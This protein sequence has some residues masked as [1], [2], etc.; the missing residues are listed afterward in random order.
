MYEPFVVTTTQL[1][2][3]TVIAI[4]GEL[5][6]ATCEE[7][8]AALDDA[9]RDESGAGIGVDLR[10]LSFC[11]SSGLKVLLLAMRQAAMRRIDVVMTRPPQP[12]WRVF[13]VSALDTV[14]P[15]VDDA[16]L[17]AVVTLRTG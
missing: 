13:E 3:R 1:S 7:L 4:S 10:R 15:F 8:K 2:G 16:A 17:D 11:D 6:I 9:L 12:A 14:L 5:D